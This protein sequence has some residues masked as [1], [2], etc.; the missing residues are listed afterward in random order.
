MALN[1][2]QAQLREQERNKIAQETKIANTPTTASAIYNAILT[3]QDIPVE[4]KASGAYRVANNRYQRVN[5][6]V[7]MTPSE[8]NNAFTS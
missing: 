3:K 7:N 6:Y 8:V 5:Q 1:Q 2:Q 4:Q